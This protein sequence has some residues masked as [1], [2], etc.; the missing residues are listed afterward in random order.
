MSFKFISSQEVIEETCANI[1]LCKTINSDEKRDCWIGETI[2]KVAELGRR[3]MVVMLFC[4][5]Y[6]MQNL[7]W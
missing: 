3:Q 6:M 2:V 5:P 7:V 1:F 4:W